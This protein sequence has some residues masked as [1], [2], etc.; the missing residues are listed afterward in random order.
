ML[1]SGLEAITGGRQS[2]FTIGT[3]FWLACGTFICM[4]S[5]TLVND[6]RNVQKHVEKS[7]SYNN[8]GGMMGNTDIDTVA[9]LQA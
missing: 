2:A 4:I 8:D 1:I 6:E 5:F 7:G 3:L 9:L